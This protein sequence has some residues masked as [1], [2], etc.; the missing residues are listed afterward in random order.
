MFLHYVKAIPAF[1][2][3]WKMKMYVVV[4]QSKCEGGCGGIHMILAEF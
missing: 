3:T 2:V 1:N 4:A